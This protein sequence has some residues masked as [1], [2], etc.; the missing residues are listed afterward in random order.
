M[1]YRDFTKMDIEKVD[2]PANHPFAMKKQV[3]YN[4]IAVALRTPH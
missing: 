2:L 1:Q 4:Y 3:G